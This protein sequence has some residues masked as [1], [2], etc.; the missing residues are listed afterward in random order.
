[1]CSRIKVLGVLVLFL[2]S[3]AWSF[4]CVGPKTASNFAVYLHGMDTQKPSP[5][6]QSNRKKLSE[7]ANKLNLRIAIPRAAD[8]CSNDKNLICWG[9][10]FNDSKIIDATLY[11]SSKAEAE[12]FPKKKANG[13]IG[14]SNGGFVVN[15]IVKDCKK[16]EFSWFVSIG[17]AGSWNDSSTEDLSQCGKISLLAGKQDKAN[18]ENIKNLAAWFHKNKAPAQLI[19]YEGGHEIPEKE[20]EQEL[21]GYLAK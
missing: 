7:I 15:Q 6:E 8:L 20:L 9:W 11:L 12:C 2:S 14:F 10:N 19:M 3:T 21:K 4:E 1:M 5:Q 16:T 13:L 18:Y 17:A